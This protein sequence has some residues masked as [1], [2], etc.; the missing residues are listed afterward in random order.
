MNK[1]KEFIYEEDGLGVVEIILIVV[2][3]IGLVVLFRNSI[4][5]VINGI[6]DT[7]EEREQE[8]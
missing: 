3:I 2:V 5:E 6:F 4:T 1:I 8:I 7:I